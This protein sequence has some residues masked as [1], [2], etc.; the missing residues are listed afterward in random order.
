MRGR[1]QRFAVIGSRG[2][3]STYGGFETFVRRLAPYL[4]DQG[5]DVTVYGR[6]SRFTV[7][8]RDVEGIRVVHTPGIDRPISSTLTYGLTSIA[9]AVLQRPDAVLV[10]NVANGYW[11]PLLRLARIPAV[12]N[13]D[14]I[15]WERDK[16]SRTGK[17]V[18]HLGARITARLADRIVVDSRAVG[19]Y[20]AERFGVNSTYIPYGADVEVGIGYERLLELGLT[21][22]TYLL[23]VARLVPENNVELFLNA[24]RLLPPEVPAVVVGS[25]AGESPIEGRL[26]EL[27][28]SRKSFL[29]LG[30]VADQDLLAQLWAHC[31]LYVHGHS[32]GGTNPALLQALGMGSAT[33]A[34][35]TVYNREVLGDDWPTYTPG[36]PFAL[37][38]LMEA[39]IKNEDKRRDLVVRGRA[40]IAT[41]YRWNDVL[42]D[43]LDALDRAKSARAIDVSD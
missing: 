7:R 10:L 37:A 40:I 29:W 18:F 30:H 19:D 6:E 8:R 24:L 4:R 36:D 26:R 27:E 5:C 39:L 42:R 20:W 43:Y 9:H 1:P 41:R 17:A 2:Y 12:V 21:R 15:E 14:G 33:I 35:D 32:V 23:V 16:W 28:K 3:P 34:L 11:L 25:A 13:V 31:A 38:R 22:G